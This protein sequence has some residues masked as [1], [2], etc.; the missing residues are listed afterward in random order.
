M[1]LLLLHLLLLPGQEA[2][3]ALVCAAGPHAAPHLHLRAAGKG[4]LGFTI[5]LSMSAKCFRDACW[6]MLL[7]LNTAS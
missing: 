3:G 6:C 4:F 7:F 5:G 1:S 2:A